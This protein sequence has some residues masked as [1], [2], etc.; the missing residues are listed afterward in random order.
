MCCSPWGHKELETTKGTE[1]NSYAYSFNFFP[2][3]SISNEIKRGWA[4]LL[5]PSGPPAGSLVRSPKTSSQS[6]EGASS[7]LWPN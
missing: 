2:N 7:H 6:L 1:L 3:A 4:L 5:G